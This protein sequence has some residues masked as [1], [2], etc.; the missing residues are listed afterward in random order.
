MWPRTETFTGSV[1]R[2]PSCFCSGS[3]C[4]G[5]TLSRSSNSSVAVLVDVLNAS[6]KRTLASG[7]AWKVD[8]CAFRPRHPAQESKPECQYPRRRAIPN[9]KRIVQSKKRRRTFLRQT[10]SRAQF[11]AAV[12][13]A[14]VFEDRHLC[15]DVV[16][17]ERILSELHLDAE[18]LL[19]EIH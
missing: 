2:T 1:Q 16:N 10:P 15:A 5:E 11:N 19:H 8:R 13:V 9:P 6:W 14:E 17:H 3:H 7:R 18:F 4:F 12:D